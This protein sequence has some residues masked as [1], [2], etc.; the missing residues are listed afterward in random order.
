MK[1]MCTY[2]NNYMWFQIIECINLIM[3][4]ECFLFIFWK[5]YSLIN[6]FEISSIIYFSLSPSWLVASIWKR[7]YFY[8]RIFVWKSMYQFQINYLFYSLLALERKKKT[9]SIFVGQ[10]SSLASYFI[11]SL[12]CIF[13]DVCI[14]MYLI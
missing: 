5:I 12:V 13:D 8:C 11:S 9:P 3:L 1:D 2:N 4:C 10:I 7:K 14:Y 6:C